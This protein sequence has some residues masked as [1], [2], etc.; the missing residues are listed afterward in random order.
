MYEQV[1]TCVQLWYMYVHVYSSE[2]ETNSIGVVT[3]EIFV[4]RK[5]IFV[6]ETFLGMIPYHG[7]II[8]MRMFNFCSCHQLHL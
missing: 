1:S 5:Q 2:V 6:L 4:L 8:G 7:N 3:L